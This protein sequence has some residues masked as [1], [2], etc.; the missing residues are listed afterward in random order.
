MNF[1]RMLRNS[2]T[3]W[4]ELRDVMLRR[5]AEA[6]QR[7]DIPPE[8]ELIGYVESLNDDDFHRT[9]VICGAFMAKARGYDVFNLPHPPT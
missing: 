9:L 1:F 8:A 5:R 2:A 7:M 6:A 3:D 4:N